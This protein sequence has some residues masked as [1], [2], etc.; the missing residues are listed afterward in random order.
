MGWF[1]VFVEMFQHRKVSI[2]YF[3]EKFKH[4]LWVYYIERSWIR[5]SA[6]VPFIFL[7]GGEGLSHG[8]VHVESTGRE[9]CSNDG[10]VRGKKKVI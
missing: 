2:S 1:M 5:P 3:E 9:V 7:G 4:K 8:G 6:R 10:S